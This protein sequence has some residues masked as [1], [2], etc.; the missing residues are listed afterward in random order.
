M[1]SSILQ[2]SLTVAVLLTGVLIG[3][4]GMP[5][6]DLRVV[7]PG[8]RAECPHDWAQFFA[9]PKAQPPVSRT[10]QGPTITLA[11]RPDRVFPAVI[12][13]S[14]ISFL[15]S[16]EITNIP[17]FHDCQR[18]ISTDG[19]GKRTFAQLAAIFASDRT[20]SVV[21]A[22]GPFVIAEVFSEGA[23][24]SL[25]IHAGFHC[26]LVD[27]DNNRALM[28]FLGSSHAGSS[29]KALN[30]DTLPSSLPAYVLAL[31]KDRPVHEVPAVARWEW[32][33]A[34]QQQLIGIKCRVTQWCTVGPTG[35]VAPNPDVTAPPVVRVA[36]WS[37]DQYLAD[38]PTSG[39]T[40]GNAFA[41]AFPAENLGSYK[42]IEEFD[43]DWFLVAQVEMPPGYPGTYTTKLGFGATPTVTN[44]L[45]GLNQVF[46]CRGTFVECKVPLGDLAVKAGGCTTASWSG[47]QMWAK[48]VPVTG[49]KP[50]YH[51][52]AYRP[53]P[54]MTPTATSTAMEHGV[55]DIPGVVRWRWRADDETIWVRC[56]AGCCEVHA[57]KI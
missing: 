26:L 35:F 17:E 22:A 38:Y 10:P 44:K 16:G 8:D 46:F 51:C 25:G 42:K 23:Y 9:G 2:R 55:F 11:P 4:N 32:D 43:N 40:P 57:G 28:L 53:H 30:P 56:P 45:A 6:D 1:K 15:I 24:P 41:R 18:L 39:I 36:G 48:V 52:V 49:A 37:D 47:K 21:A 12:A 54:T 31:E 3:C 7:A 33:S 34:A 13:A 27:P 14:A 19:T 5:V 50:L 29:C 20:D